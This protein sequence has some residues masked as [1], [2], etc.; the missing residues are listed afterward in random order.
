MSPV[1][2]KNVKNYKSKCKNHEP[3]PQQQSQQSYEVQQGDIKKFCMWDRITSTALLKRT[4]GLWWVIR[5]L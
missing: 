3:L 4:W 2:S 1:F 5:G